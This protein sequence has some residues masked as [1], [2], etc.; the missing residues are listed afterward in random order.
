MVHRQPIYESDRLDPVDPAAR[1]ELHRERLERFPVGYR[2]LAYLQT[3]IGYD[4]KADMP[5]LAGAELDALYG[6]GARWLAGATAAE[7]AL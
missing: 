2:H 5:G 7:L 3:E 1:L 6:R 4:V